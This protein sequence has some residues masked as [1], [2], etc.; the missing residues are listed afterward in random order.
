MIETGLS[1][2]HKM[3]HFPKIKQQ[4]ISYWKYKDFNNKTFLDLLKRELN[5]QGQFLNEK[6]LDVFSTI[7]T[8]IFD[9]HAPKKRRYIRSTH[10]PFINNE[11]SKATMTRSR[12]RNR[13][14]KNRSEENRKL[15]CKQRNKCVSLLRKSKKDYFASLNEK[16]ITDNIT[17]F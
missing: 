10:K 8:E 7:C 3:V 15:F 11:I 13:Y 16:S 17:S 9:K 14:L 1:D 6:K 4:V 2:F 5:V 12:L